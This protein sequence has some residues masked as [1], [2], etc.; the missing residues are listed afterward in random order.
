[1]AASVSNGSVSSCPAATALWENDTGFN[2]AP[3]TIASLKT[4]LHAPV[5]LD[6]LLATRC[7]RDDGIIVWTAAH[8]LA[9][10]CLPM[11]ARRGGAKERQRRAQRAATTKALP[12]PG[13]DL[14][15][16]RPVVGAVP[17][18]YYWRKRRREGVEDTAQSPHMGVG[19]VEGQAGASAAP[20]G[21]SLVEAQMEGSQVQP[22]ASAA[23]AGS[24][25]IEDPANDS[26]TR[27]GSSS[28]EAHMEAEPPALR[29]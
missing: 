28:M 17:G 22:G 3:L 16:Q 2:P 29:E 1:M 11:P 20:A 25:P 5:A 13:V 19:T 12:G 8:Q 14:S 7:L 18:Q 15:L 23:P 10:T 4:S 24:S 6:L 27:T 21:S 9:P 26:A